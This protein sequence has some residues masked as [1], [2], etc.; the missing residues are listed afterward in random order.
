M[1][2][3]DMREAWQAQ[4]LG[5]APV[6][7]EELH[8]KS[9]RFRSRI[10]RRNLRE[11]LAAAVVAAWFGYGAWRAG[12][13]VMRA[14]DALVV[15]GDFYVA[16]ELHRRAS[17]SPVQGAL[18]WLSC[19]E[20]HRTQLARQRDALASVWKWYL[21]PFLPGLAVLLGQGCLNGF[22]HSATIGLVTLIPLGFVALLLW[23]V[24]RLNRKAAARIQKQ[25]DALDE[26]GAGGA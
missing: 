10:A 25:I 7:L 21:G 26:L 22:R 18:A 5:V 9:G 1:P 17:A 11:Y 16:F 24:G 14:G 20:F 15:L 6:T 2:D 19:M 8:R 3:N 12:D 13:P 4:G 23:G